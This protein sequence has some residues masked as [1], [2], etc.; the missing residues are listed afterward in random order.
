GHHIAFVR[1]TDGE[2]W[3]YN[4]SVVT[5][6]ALTRYKVVTSGAYILTYAK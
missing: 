2:W 3:R 4:D 1:D 5:T 6:V